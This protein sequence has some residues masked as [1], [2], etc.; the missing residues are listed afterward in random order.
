MNT[1][2]DFPFHTQIKVH[3]GDMD[4]ASHV[5]N[6]IYLRWSETARIEFF[7]KVFAGDFNFSKGIGPIL[8]WQDC[9][10]IFP[11]TYPDVALIG[12][13]VGEILEDRYFMEVRVFSQ[14]HQRLAAISKQSIMA[15]DYGN[16]RKATIPES[17]LKGLNKYV[18]E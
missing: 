11:M 6:L 14:Q 1:H 18:L 9:K 13:K 8:A 4:A 3:W 17:W 5:N 10:Y 16:L 7:D 15:Y 2:L 12:L